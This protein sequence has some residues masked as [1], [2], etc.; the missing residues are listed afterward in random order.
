VTTV[1]MA[2]PHLDSLYLCV[3]LSMQ[4]VMVNL[5]NERSLFVI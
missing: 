5:M 4:H 2:N 1:I 3:Q